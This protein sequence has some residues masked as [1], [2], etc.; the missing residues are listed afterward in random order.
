MELTTEQRDAIVIPLAHVIEDTAE[1]DYWEAKDELTHLLEFGSVDEWDQTAAGAIGEARRAG[2]RDADL[3]DATR[4]FA[5]GR[6]YIFK[7]PGLMAA[8]SQTR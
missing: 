2:Y 8:L 7:D 5:I 6:G 4:A 3:G 1:V